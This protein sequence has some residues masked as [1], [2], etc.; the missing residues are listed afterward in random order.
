MLTENIAK[1]TKNIMSGKVHAAKII[2]DMPIS[3][4]TPK[5][6]QALP[7]PFLCSIIFA[8]FSVSDLLIVNI[9]SFRADRK[10]KNVPYTIG[11]KAIKNNT[12]IKIVSESILNTTP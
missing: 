9:F 11:M 10:Y 12:V 5:K 7:L 1:P 3:A 6:Q 4:I 2:K 8:S